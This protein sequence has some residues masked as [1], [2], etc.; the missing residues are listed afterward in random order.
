MSTAIAV[1]PTVEVIRREVAEDPERRAQLQAATGELLDAASSFLTSYVALPDEHCAAVLAL[2]ALHTWVLDACDAT[3]YM[4]IVSAEKG[5]GKTRCLEALSYLVRKPW[6]TANTTPTAL[7][8]RMSEDQPTLL[9]DELDAIFRG[10]AGHE[11]LRQVLNAGNRRGSTITRCDG[12]WKTIEYDTFGA[13]VLAGIDTGF[14]PETVLDRSIV[15]RMRKRAPD[16]DPLRRLRPRATAAEAAPL[17]N[18]LRGWALVTTEA[19]AKLE[20]EIPAALSDRAADAWEPLLAIA[21]FAAGVWPDRARSAAQALSAP[22][23]G[24]IRPDTSPEP[25]PGLLPGFAR[26]FEPQTAQ[27]AA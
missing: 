13:K 18:T 4:V 1:R 7:F 12:A 23:E 17:A 15:I 11:A 16:A 6:Q 19:L 9:L 26:L 25:T 14:L 5:S 10:G 22:A 2:Y 8:R 24:P 3:P 20:P 21:D 27:V